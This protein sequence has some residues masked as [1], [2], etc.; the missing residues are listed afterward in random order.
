MVKNFSLL[1]GLTHFNSRFIC[2][3]SNFFWQKSLFCCRLCP[4]QTTWREHLPR[5]LLIP[6]NHISPRRETEKAA[7]KTSAANIW[8]HRI[9]PCRD[10][11]QKLVQ[12]SVGFYSG[13]FRMAT[14]LPV[15]VFKNQS[16][17]NSDL[18]RLLSCDRERRWLHGETRTAGDLVVCHNAFSL[19]LFLFLLRDAYET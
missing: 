14:S 5:M 7:A 12:E 4:L 3:I 11:V 9:A 15:S 1:S 16:K 6:V 17:A 19:A 10:F 13:V 8:L 2:Y 18:S